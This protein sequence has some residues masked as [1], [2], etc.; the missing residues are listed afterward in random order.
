MLAID[1]LSSHFGEWNEIPHADMPIYSSDEIMW[2]AQFD[3]IKSLLEWEEN[4]RKIQKWD[5]VVIC[6]S[7]CPYDNSLQSELDTFYTI[8]HTRFQ[9]WAIKQK[10]L[11]S[12]K[13]LENGVVEM[14]FRSNTI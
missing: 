5:D 6:Y 1:S 4:K 3:G 11:Y 9:V 2:R 12:Q 10:L 13:I 7:V 8:F 14:T